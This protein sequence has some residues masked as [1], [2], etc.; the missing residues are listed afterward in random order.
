MAKTGDIA[1]IID[2]GCS[3][4]G[5]LSFTGTAKINGRVNGNI[6]SNDTVIISEGAVVEADIV[7]NIVLI[8]GSVKGNVKASGRVEIVKPARFEGTIATPSLVVEEGVIF[9]GKTKMSDREI[10]VS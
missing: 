10:S 9:H 3:F 7:A 2:E 1:A 5:N 6:F 4:E 8:S